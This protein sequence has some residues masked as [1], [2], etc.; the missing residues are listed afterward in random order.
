[1]VI[2]VVGGS[3][4]SLLVDGQQVSSLDGS[5]SGSSSSS[6]STTT[7]VTVNGKTVSSST[8]DINGV[9]SGS[10]GQITGNP[11]G[12]LTIN[13]NNPSVTLG[14]STSSDSTTSSTGSAT[15]STVSSTTISSTTVSGLSTPSVGYKPKYPTGANSPFPTQQFPTGPS[16]NFIPSNLPTQISNYQYTVNSSR[17]EYKATVTDIQSQ[18]IFQRQI[19]ANK[20]VANLLSIIQQL[21]ANVNGV[22]ADIPAATAALNLAIADQRTIQQRIVAAENANKTLTSNIATVRVDITTFQQTLTKVS[23]NLNN[24]QSYIDGNNSLKIVVVANLTDAQNRATSLQNALVAA[25]DAI[26]DAQSSISSLNIN[27][28][29]YQSQI[30]SIQQDIDNAPS[31]IQN[32]DRQVKDIS[33][34]IAAL[35][36]QLAALRKQRDD[37]SN[38]SNYY[39]TINVT[40]GAQIR[41]L[42]SLIKTLNIQITGTYQPIID[43]A[44]TN[45]A[46]ITTDLNTI[47]TL[48][49]NLNARS[50]QIDIAIATSKRNRDGTSAQYTSIITSINKSTTILNSLLAQAPA[51]NNALTQAYN[52]GNDANDRYAQLKAVLDALNV[53]YHTSLKELN[54]AKSA[55]EKARAEKEISDLAVNE[56]IR[57]QGGSTILPYS[58]PGT[59]TGTTSTTVITAGGPSGGRWIVSGS[60]LK[61]GTIIGKTSSGVPIIAG[62]TS[63]GATGIVTGRTTNGGFVI[64]G[65]GSSQGTVIGTTAGGNTIVAGQGT[66]ITTKKSHVPNVRPTAPTGDLTH[67]ISNSLTSGVSSENLYPFVLKWTTGFANFECSGSETVEETAVISG[68][69]QGSL[70]VTSNAGEQLQLN[71]GG[72][73]KLQANKQDYEPS[74]GDRVR[75]SGWKNSSSKKVN[76]AAIACYA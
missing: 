60:G 35:E 28:S 34:T 19:N 2:N 13:L 76:A 29:T 33:T 15:G 43:N 10:S 56:Q 65:F 26:K 44:N 5:V 8:N 70:A 59:T 7:T 27:I 62:S 57:K 32:Y 40:G 30:S 46:K 71:V 74:V 63:T 73:T 4:G 58:I 16:A 67:Y 52:D 23:V 75:W 22:Q 9:F 66:I 48:I 24:G 6:Q 18:A 3:S 42:Q 55:L 11:S 36:A 53:K 47:Q 39:K 64:S 51:Y 41:Q 61:E 54:D 69:Y 49:A 68:I 1:M 45:I 38:K 17:D 21:T 20:A 14:G 25:N 12:S 72:C 50:Q 31:Y 37:I